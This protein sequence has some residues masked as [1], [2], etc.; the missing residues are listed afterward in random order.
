MASAVCLPVLVLH[1]L[2]QTFPKHGLS[3]GFVKRCQEQLKQ[4]NTSEQHERLYPEVETPVETGRP[5]LDIERSHWWL[6]KVLVDK[7]IPM[8]PPRV[9]Q[10]KFDLNREC[11]KTNHTP[12]K[13]FTCVHDNSKLFC[14]L[15]C[16]T[17]HEKTN[18]FPT[19]DDL[20]CS[21][22]RTSSNQEMVNYGIWHESHLKN[23]CVMFFWIWITWH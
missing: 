7:C 1:E 20:P 4:Q 11:F 23:S 5:W 6:P 16:L 12:A 22:Y 18:I 14:A 13:Q 2:G 10:H 8:R 17:S 19:R 21:S 3:S 9:T 15:I